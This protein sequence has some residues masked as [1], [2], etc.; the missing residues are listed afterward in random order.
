MIKFKLITKRNPEQ[1]EAA[2]NKALEDGWDM[3]SAPIIVEE[4]EVLVYHQ[5]MAKE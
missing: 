4:D 2:V 1:F 3:I 5:S